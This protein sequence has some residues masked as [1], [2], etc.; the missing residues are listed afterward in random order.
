MDTVRT[1]HHPRGRGQRSG[2]GVGE[3]GA[4]YPLGSSSRDGNSFKKEHLKGKRE[5]KL[6]IL[7][8]GIGFGKIL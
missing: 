6:D 7:I 3:I 4:E 1:T 5:R 2:A 8:A